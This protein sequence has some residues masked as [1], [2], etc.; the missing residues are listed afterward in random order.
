[1]ATET[2][3]INLPADVWTE[4][5]SGVDDVLVQRSG[6]VGEVMISVGGSMPTE[7]ARGIILAS[8]ND[9]F[10]A[11]DLGAASVFAKALGH[12]RPIVV[13]RRSGV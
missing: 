6:G 7:D 4:I 12:S 11:G 13:M 3:S 5:A 9:V 1:M 8:S 2:V 10:S